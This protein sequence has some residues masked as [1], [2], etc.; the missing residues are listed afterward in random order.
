MVQRTLAAMEHDSRTPPK[1]SV[2]DLLFVLFLR[3]VALSCLVFGVQ[4]WGMLSGYLLEGRARFDLLSLP[5][6]VAGAGLSVVFPVAAL[7]LWLTVSWGPV[8]W[9]LAA[10]AQVAMYTVWPSIFGRN[11]PLVLLHATVAI[12]FALFRIEAA[13]RSRQNAHGVRVDSP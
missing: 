9:V 13:Y 11:M 5:W 8:I 4:Y 10:G 12:L 1:R 2:I 6:K 7:G 3:L